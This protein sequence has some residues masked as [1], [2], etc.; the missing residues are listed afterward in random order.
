MVMVINFM[1]FNIQHGKDYIKQV[2]DLDLMVDTIQKCQG[3]IIS[4]N[5][6]FGANWQVKS[7]AEIIASKLGYHYYFGEAIDYKGVP[8]GNAVISKYSFKNCE[9]IMIPDPIRNTNEF[10][11]TRCIIKVEYENPNFVVLVSHFGLAETEKKNAVRAVVNLINSINTPIVL[12]GDL[13]MIPEDPKLEP[14]YNLLT[15]TLKGTKS[16]SFPST[17][18]TRKIDYIFVSKD[19]VIQEANIL[20]I[21]ASDHFPHTAILEINNKNKD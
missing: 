5:E 6:V 13:N 21:V 18:P 9:T 10:Y 17:N 8:Y 12:M 2:I 7:Q 20:A 1:T 15:D 16:F 14:I 3:E 19:I 11:E 4:L